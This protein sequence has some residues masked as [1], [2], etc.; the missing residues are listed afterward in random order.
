VSR[1][2]ARARAH[3]PGSGN[4]S[5]LSD[6]P[7]LARHHPQRTPCAEGLRRGRRRQTRERTGDTA[8]GCRENR[9][10]GHHFSRVPGAAMI[11]LL[12]WMRLVFLAACG[13]LAASYVWIARRTD[14]EERG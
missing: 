7:Q 4:R 8:A 12:L 13:A 1:R 3:P 10:G 6:R 11:T 14:Q 9:P 5:L 2:L